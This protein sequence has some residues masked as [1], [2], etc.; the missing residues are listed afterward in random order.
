MV[1]K[2]MTRTM[3]V[4]L[5]GLGIMGNHW[6]RIIA[7]SPEV[8]L[9][10]VVEPVE[11]LAAERIKQH[12]IDPAL[13][14][15][16]FQQALETARPDGV[17]LVTP[18]AL[19]A[20]MSIAALELGIPVLCEKP[21]AESMESGLAILRKAEETG[22]LHMVA[23]DYRY[24][25][26]A[27]TVKQVL[28][29]GELGPVGAVTV[30]FFKSVMRSGFHDTLAYP[31]TIDMSIHHFDM[32]R[33]FLDGEPLSI[34]GLAWRTPWDWWRGNASAAVMLAFANGPVVT[35]TGSWCATGQE[36]PWNANWRFECQNGVLLLQDDR[37]ILQ[38]R[39]SQI[40]D[41]LGYHRYLNEPPARVRLKR[42]RR[43]RQAHLLHE[44]YLAVARGSRP[45]TTVQD[46]I[47]SFR[48]V[49][50]TISSFESGQTV[51]IEP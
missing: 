3:R 21:L 51:M 36:T 42:P 4:A 6:L 46:N 30:Q 41:S 47:H 5:A 22:V 40:D 44:F 19:H 29:S 32:M 38:R 13:H 18:P 1:T 43:Q 28:A 25:A 12:G 33:F 14:F 27:Q 16:S 48:M 15:I 10:A 9:V 17:I 35:Y 7:A 49:W 34:H 26:Q 45:A 24:S 11:S 2:S 20:P 8:E 37:V 23:Q 31:L 39:T 50:D